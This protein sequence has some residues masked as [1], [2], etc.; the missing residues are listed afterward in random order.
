MKEFSMRLIRGTV[1]CVAVLVAFGGVSHIRSVQAADLK[2][3]DI[4]ARHLDSIGSAEARVAKSRVEQ[5]T[6]SFRVLVG[7]AG[8]LTGKSGIVSEGHKLQLLISFPN[9]PYHGERFICDGQRVSVASS[10]SQQ[11]RSSFAEFV[12]TQDAILRE[13]LLTGT[14]S[15]AWP[16]LDLDQRKPKLSYEGLKKID[17]RPLHDIQY[18]PKKSSDLQIH[19]YFDPE[20]FRHVETVYELS[21]SPNVGATI[22]ESAQQKEN[23]YQITEKFSD[24]KTTDGLTLPT[25]YDLQFSRELQDGTTSLWD[26][27][28]TFDQVS[29]NVGLD[30]R[31][32]EIK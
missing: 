28:L 29:N 19:L 8:E 7:G 18:H 30:P 26:W 21:F 14:L 10:T 32:F 27:N 24:F 15:T 5:G 4:I 3:E 1:F 13:G 11:T 17:G 22:T 20:T 2:P 9:Q 23:R 16:L 31:N 6:A 12:R 25:H